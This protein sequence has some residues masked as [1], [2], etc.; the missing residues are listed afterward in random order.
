MKSPEVNPLEDEIDKLSDLDRLRVRSAELR[1]RG[2]DALLDRD[3][4][5]WQESDSPVEEALIVKAL[6]D[7]RTGAQPPQELVTSL[8][9]MKA[10]DIFDDAIKIPVLRAARAMQAL[11]V[12]PSSAFSEALVLFY[13]QIIREIYS[14]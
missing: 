13:Y 2:R 9:S 4:E 12:A 10:K 6:C 3:N 11:A 8:E 7:R 1:N 14:A 5:R